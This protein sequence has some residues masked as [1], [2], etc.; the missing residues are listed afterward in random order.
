MGMPLEVQT[1]IVTKGKAERQEDYS[2]RLVKAGYRLYPLDVPL[3]VHKTKDAKSHA[4]ATIYS[5]TW[6][7]N[8]T[9]IQYKLLDLHGVN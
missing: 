2:Y 9:E 7:E 8:K 5:L 3:T 4:I 6:H 1:M